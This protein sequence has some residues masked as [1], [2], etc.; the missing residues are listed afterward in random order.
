M[1]KD[2]LSCFAFSTFAG[3]GPFL[4]KKLL[5]LFKTPYRAY[6][7]TFQELRRV[8]SA[9]LAA[10]FIE[11]RGSF[12]LERAWK[13]ILQKKIAYVAGV[14]KKFPPLLSQI[15][16]PPIGLFY[17]GNWSNFN[18]DKDLFFAIVGTRK[19]SSYGANIAVKIAGELSR[20][21]VVVVSGMALGIDACAHSGALSVGG[22][23]I[24]VLSCG[25]D[26]VYPSSNFYIYTKILEQGGLVLSEFPPGM[27]VQRRLFVVRNRIIS[28][29]SHGVLV[30]EG[31][32]RS[33]TLVTARHAAEQGRDLFVVPGQIDLQNSQ[34]P[35]LLLK[36]GAQP[37]T[38]AA[39]ILDFFKIARPKKITENKKTT[40]SILQ[41]TILSCLKK[42]HLT[43]EEIFYKTRVSIDKLLYELSILE[44][45]GAIAKNEE[46]KW[47][48]KNFM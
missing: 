44:I 8:L 34:A 7:A 26:V 43:T 42:E 29:L 48:L 31:G 33:G 37:V 5:S 10:K 19:A 15:V 46:G 12:N 45:T 35:L 24:A 4:F 11:F 14:D 6:T 3:I 47:F 27:R 23:T 2:A 38:S 40:T 1:E 39:D 20:A 18:W 21:G 9:A 22:K 41:Q 13:E 17:K 25:V 30:V 32:E 28:G 16:D 36:Q